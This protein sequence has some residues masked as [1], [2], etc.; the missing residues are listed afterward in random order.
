MTI[1]ISSGKEKQTATL[2][3]P[4]ARSLNSNK[5]PPLSRPEVCHPSTACLMRSFS[6]MATKYVLTKPYLFSARVMRRF[7]RRSPA[8]LSPR[9]P[10]GTGRRP[11]AESRTIRARGTP[12]CVALLQSPWRWRGRIIRA[13]RSPEVSRA[14]FES[15]DTK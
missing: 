6:F 9:R 1:K 3:F 5:D 10:D 12:H 11:R 14:S 7:V 2:P 13:F 8:R 15:A 4:A